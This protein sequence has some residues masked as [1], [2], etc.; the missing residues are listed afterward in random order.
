MNVWDSRTL[1]EQEQFEYYHDVICRAFVPLLPIAAQDG[2]GGFASRV[3]TRSLGELN[4]AAVSSRKQATHHGP[5][6]VAATEAPYYFV[7]LQLA[8]LCAVRH[9][10][11]ESI[12]APGQ[13]TV[14]DTTDPFYLDF[15]G[16]WSM[17]SFRLPHEMLDDR[18]RGHRLQ[19]GSTIGP[20]GTGGAAVALTNALWA[21]GDEPGP[22]AAADL[23][24][25][26]AAA[27]AAALAERQLEV[28]ETPAE[29]LR[30]LVLRH[31]HRR[32]A[33]PTLSVTSVSRAFSL[34]PRS[35][36]ALFEE[37]ELTFAATLRAL[38]VQRAVELLQIGRLS[39]TEVGEAVGYPDPSS[40][41]R[42]FRRVTGAAPSSFRQ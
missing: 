23:S 1:P 11:N 4:R 22:A 41:G 37:E 12:V 20:E 27:V 13:F 7:N 40:F 24:L 18:T 36:H 19:L 25:A 3:Q 2:A 6:E 14:L 15:D 39:V 38:R 5:T 17:L 9:R 29:G 30:A 31:L 26:F 42:A 33:D 16:D 34:S 21:M 10:G 35:L 32:M 28:S 8:G